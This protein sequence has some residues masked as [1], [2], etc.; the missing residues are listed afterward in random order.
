MFSNLCLSEGSCR[1]HSKPCRYQHFG[2]LFQCCEQQ[3]KDESLAIKIPGCTRGKH[4]SQHHRDFFYNRYPLYVRQQVSLHNI[5]TIMCCVLGIFYSKYLCTK[6]FHT[7]AVTKLFVCV[8]PYA[9]QCMWKTG[10]C[11]CVENSEIWS[12]LLGMPQKQSDHSTECTGTWLYYTLNAYNFTKC[13]IRSYYGLVCD[14]Q[15]MAKGC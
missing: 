15:A 14:S 7:E 13:M 10:S 3:T 4:S 1:Y 12:I 9:L 6:K 8:C 11:Q 2:Y 5:L